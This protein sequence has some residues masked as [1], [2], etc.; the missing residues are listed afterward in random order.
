MLIDDEPEILNCLGYALSLKGISH[1]QYE[2]PFRALE[3][4][5]PAEFDVVLTDLKMRRVNGM[6]VL[7]LVRARDPE[8]CVLLMTGYIDDL[9]LKTAAEEG[10]YAVF[11]KPLD[12]RKILKMISEIDKQRQT[13][14]DQSVR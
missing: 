3:A 8:V 2:D 10:A 5:K 13:K 12:L 4:F 6:E 11:P 7:R 9:E 14:R 1:V